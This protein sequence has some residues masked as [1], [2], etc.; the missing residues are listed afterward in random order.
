MTERERLT[1]RYW[2]TLRG[3]DYFIYTIIRGCAHIYIYRRIAAIIARERDLGPRSWRR[4]FF[5]WLQQHSLLCIYMAITYCFVWIYSL[6]IASRN[7]I[8]SAGASSKRIN[9]LIECEYYVRIQYNILYEKRSRKEEKKNWKK[10][11]LLLT[12]GPRWCIII[13]YRYIMTAVCICTQRFA[14]W[15]IS[16]LIQGHFYLFPSQFSRIY[17]Q[18][19]IAIYAPRPYRYTYIIYVYIRENSIKLTSTLHLYI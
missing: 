6:C 3:V 2:Y 19:A 12:R 14:N 13:L 18:R 5:G 10:I 17:M 9:S 8:D 11:E 1:F 7:S 4:Q 15:A 16:D